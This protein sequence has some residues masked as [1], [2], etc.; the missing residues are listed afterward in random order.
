MCGIAG[1]LSRDPSA[2]PGGPSAIAAR[3]S[4]S[5]AR[6]GPDASGVLTLLDGQ[7]TLI[8]RRLSILD[9]SSAGAQPMQSRCSRFTV[10]FNGEIYNHLDLRRE[11]PSQIWRGSSDTETLLQ[12]ISHWGVSVTL[13]K[14]VGMFAFCVLDR[15]EQALYLARDRLGE[16]PLVYQL[17]DGH[18]LFAS[19]VR[20]LGM[21]PAASRSLD[22]RSVAQQIRYGFVTGE[23]T[24]YAGVRRLPQGSYLKLSA[25][26]LSL[27]V[28]SYW[29]ERQ[30][31]GALA[32][33]AWVGDNVTLDKELDELLT[34]SVASQMM[35]DVPLGAFL[36]GGIDSSLIAAL[37]QKVS[38]KPIETFCIGFEHGGYDET[39]KARAI[40]KALG[41]KHHEMRITHDH[42]RDI[43]PSA[44]EAYDEPFSDPSQLPTLL[45]CQFA[46]SRVT[47]A[48]SGDGGDELFGGYSRH[49]AVDGLARFT[50]AMPRWSRASLDWIVDALSGPATA[51][52]QRWVGFTDP[53]QAFRKLRSIL[54]H[55]VGDEL[56]ANLISRISEQEL[57]AV[58]GSLHESPE[59]QALSGFPGNLPASTRVRFADMACYLPD[60]I[61]VKVDR[62]AMY[63]SLETR[64]PFLDHRVVEFAARLSPPALYANRRGKA[65]L[66]RVLSRYL[67]EVLLAGQKH[68]FDVPIGLWLRGGLKEWANDM[69][70][71][72]FLDRTELLDRKAIRKLWARFLNGE[73]VSQSLIW[74]TIVFSAW[75]NRTLVNNATEVTH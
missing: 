72:V 31:L 30:V 56:Y 1:F 17:I 22:A 50:A 26:D 46:R 44:L 59:L 53:E 24:I 8:H 10:V 52:L 73:E 6:R 60:D 63:H 75:F 71:D 37:M 28:H 40:A 3:M 25:H 21:H 47:V 13:T 65:P 69:L 54:K 49:L 67:P 57:S 14:L 19:D 9:L 18:F 62:A 27:T 12:A 5:L 2:L 15:D 32:T 45:L 51:G 41:T 34:Q 68:G 48:L 66:R 7:L 11:L 23:H 35:A 64:T 42:A 43:F 55:D 20:T 33:G 38:H 16:K 4:S 74:N 36:S 39:S 61:L 58:L 70:S 29:D